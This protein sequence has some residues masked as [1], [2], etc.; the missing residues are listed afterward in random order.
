[1]ESYDLSH[2]DGNIGETQLYLVSLLSSSRFPYHYW[3]G[4]RFAQ[5]LCGRLTNY[6]LLNGVVFICFQGG[7][8]EGFCI[9]S[10]QQR[11][12]ENCLFI[13][14]DLFSTTLANF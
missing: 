8:L 11:L 13:P 12:F 14:P 1:M 3:E 6:G 5:Y 10:N 7:K 2:P 4:S 9:Y